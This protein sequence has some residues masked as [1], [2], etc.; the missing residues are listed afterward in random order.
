MRYFLQEF[1]LPGELDVVLGVPAPV[2]ATI[3]GLVRRGSE[4]KALLN[5]EWAIGHEG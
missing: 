1:S 2:K 3:G 5:F 4:I